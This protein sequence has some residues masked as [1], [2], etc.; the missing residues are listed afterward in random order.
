M[1]PP[2]P[3]RASPDG[4]GGAYLPQCLKTLDLLKRAGFAVADH[5]LTSRVEIV[6]FKARHAVWTTPQVFIDDKRIGGCKY[7]LRFL[8]KEVQDKD[9]VT[10]GS[11]SP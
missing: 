6:A 10:Y 9:A 1:A 8:G 5:K 2:P 4:D 11:A 3:R 7:V